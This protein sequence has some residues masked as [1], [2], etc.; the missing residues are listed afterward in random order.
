MRFSV[1]EKENILIIKI[2]DKLDA[3]TANELK[4]EFEKLLKEF[5]HFI[6]DLTN[7]N[8]INSSGLGG[9]IYCLKLCMENKKEIRLCGINENNDILFKVLKVYNIVPIYNT[10]EESI[11]DLNNFK[12]DKNPF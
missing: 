4:K 2:I 5:K 7:I 8:L 3:F 11:R 6:I 9:I 1:Y 12:I 10:I